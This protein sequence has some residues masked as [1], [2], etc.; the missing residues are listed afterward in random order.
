[1]KTIRLRAKT[2]VPI[3]TVLLANPVVTI[4]LL[5][6][7][8]VRMPQDRLRVLHVRLAH[9][10]LPVRPVVTMLLPLARQVRTPR[11]QLRV[12]TVL[13]LPTLLPS[14]VHLLRTVLLSLALWNM[15]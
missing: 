8:Q 2:V 10:V 3:R 13:L 12:K 5:L 11:E 6:V 1:M 4:Q 9:T 14:L 15:G 7:Q